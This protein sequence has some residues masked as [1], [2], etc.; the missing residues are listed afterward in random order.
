MNFDL[1]L[2]G[3]WTHGAGQRHPAGADLEVDRRG[4]DAGQRG[5][6]D[7]S[8]LPVARP[9]ALRP[10]QEAQLA[11]NSFLPSSTAL[12]RQA[13]VVASAGLGAKAAVH[14]AGEEQAEQQ[15]DGDRGRVPAAGGQ[16][17]HGAFLSSVRVR[18]SDG[19]VGDVT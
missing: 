17:V 9:S 3:A 15:Q 14:G 11:R 5:A 12:G 10:W 1:A 4:A 16:C 8:P 18:S 13:S 2:R 19:E 7:L 6:G